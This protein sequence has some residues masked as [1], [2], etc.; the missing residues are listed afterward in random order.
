VLAE[1]SCRQ[2]ADQERASEHRQL[3]RDY[4]RRGPTSPDNVAQVDVGAA[5]ANVPGP[6]YV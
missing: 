4:I 6:R 2:D 5:S 3:L 1:H